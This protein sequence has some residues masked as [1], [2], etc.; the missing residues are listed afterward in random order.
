MYNEE[1]ADRMKKLMRKHKGI[2]DKKM[3]GGVSFL[4]NG[5][6]FCGLIKDDIVVRINPDDQHLLKKRGVR[7]M[8]FTGKPMKG[9]IYVNPSG[10]KTDKILY[11]WMKTGMDFVA[12]IK[13]K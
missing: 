12:T 1:T 8:D 10:Y 11:E 2:K 3:F 4:L 13:K 6:M 7:L 5:K 9:F